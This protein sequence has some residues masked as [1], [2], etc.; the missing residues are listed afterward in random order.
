MPDLPAAASASGPGGERTAYDV[1]DRYDDAYFEDLSQRYLRRTR[2]ARRRIANV[3]ALLPALDGRVFMDLGCGMGTFAIEAARHGARSL[4]VDMMPHALR[5]AQRVAQQEK[6]ADASFVRGDV[7]RLPLRDSSVDVALA[8]DLTEHLDDGTLDAA[9]AEARRVLRPG[10]SLILYTPESSHLFERLR[11]R[12]VLLEQDSSHIG[13]RSADVLAAHVRSAGFS[14]STLRY[15]P[16]HIPLFNLL[17]RALASWVPLLRRRIGLV[18][19]R[20][21]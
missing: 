6:T 15:L 20:T 5:A 4:G 16:S 2:F 9:L 10:G 3:F 18:A 17:E 7:A 19:V 1:I 13:V 21:P 8:A 11:A 12:G 14:V